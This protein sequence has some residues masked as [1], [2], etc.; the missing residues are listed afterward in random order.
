MGRLILLSIGLVLVFLVAGCGTTKM[1]YTAKEKVSMLEQSYKSGS[2]TTA[3]AAPPPATT[4]TAVAQPESGDA[5]GSQE[6]AWRNA[7]VTKPDAIGVIIGN[8][9]YA[10]FRNGIPDVNFAHRDAQAMK[11]VFVT[12]LGLDPENIIYV[13]D[14]TQ[15]TMFSVFGTKDNPKGKLFNWIKPNVSEVYIYY[16]G[17]GAPSQTT[18]S[19]FLI[20]VDASVNYL[21]ETGYSLTTLYKNIERLPSKEN[22]VIIDACFSGDSSGGPLFKNVSP[23]MLRYASHTKQIKKTCLI[24]STSAGQLS[25]WYPQK[26]HSLFTYYLLSGLSGKADVNDDNNVTLSELKR[27]VCEEVSYRAKRLSG[28]EQTPVFMARN[29]EKVVATVK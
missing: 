4:Q 12:E 2:T 23:A 1:S 16:T 19:A 22:T 15:A 14:A 5:A 11:K 25:N 3:E 28:R 6:F 7:K 17:H 29:M 27:Y 20:P 21:N 18:Q 10:K 24:S 9:G 26:E 8:G 13:E